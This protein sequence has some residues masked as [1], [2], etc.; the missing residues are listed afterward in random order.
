MRRGPGVFILWCIVMVG[1]R[2]LDRL[3]AADRVIWDW[4]AIAF[5]F[6]ILALM[7]WGLTDIIDR[8]IT[9]WRAYRDTDTDE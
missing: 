7:V 5:V 3:V 4:L 1:S 2:H 8:C 9:Y 6:G